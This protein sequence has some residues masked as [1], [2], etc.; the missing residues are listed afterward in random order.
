MANLLPFDP[1]LATYIV[2]RAA[3]LDGTF[4]GIVQLAGSSFANHASS[5]IGLSA[6]TVIHT[7]NHQLLDR[8]IASACGIA[9]SE[10]ESKPA[11]GSLGDTV[12]G[13]DSVS[14]NC[15]LTDF[16]Q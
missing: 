15:C 5:D 4:S 12:L 11:L 8:P 1:V 9:D 16:W 7:P 10:K 3:W 6:H 2:T 14:D 13:V